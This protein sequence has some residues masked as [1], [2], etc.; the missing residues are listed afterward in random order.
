MI[1]AYWLI[2]VIIGTFIATL[3]F[4]QHNSKKTSAINAK[5]TS[6]VA[7]V[8]AEAKDLAAKVADT[9]KTS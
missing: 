6:G 9:T 3:K 8:T 4:A 5:T 2:P 1:S 7:A